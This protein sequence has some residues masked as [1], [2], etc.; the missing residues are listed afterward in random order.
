MRLEYFQML[1]R[2]AAL[3]VGA[4][5]VRSVAVVPQ[6]STIFEGHF[7]TFPL[8][9]GVLLT[10][11]MA[12]T[13]GWLI[14]AVTGFTSMPILVGI[15]EAKFRTTVLP[16]D[17]L[18]FSGQVAHE[19]SGFS[20]GDCKGLRDGKVVCEARLI[21]RLIPYPTPEFRHA[22]REWAERLDVPVKALAKELEL[23][24]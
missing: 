8:M 9:P 17:A 2:I 15:R 13:V 14:S 1:D 21:Y 7:P 20:V 3:D 11:C 4:R 18:E 5:E 22:V 24:K 16:G 12:Q 23:P 19:G 6:E 10:E